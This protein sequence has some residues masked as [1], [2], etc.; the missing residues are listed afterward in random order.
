MGVE[1]D[2]KKQWAEYRQWA[3]MMLKTIKP[4]RVNMGSEYANGWNDCLKQMYKREDKWFKDM[5]KFLEVKP[6]RQ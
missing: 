6:K 4:W 5:E 2:I 1:L 3:K